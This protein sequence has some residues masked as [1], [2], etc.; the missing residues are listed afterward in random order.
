MHHGAVFYRIWIDYREV[1]NLGFLCWLLASLILVGCVCSLGHVGNVMIVN[2][3]DALEKTPSTPL[4]LAC[5]LSYQQ[6]LSSQGVQQVNLCLC[7]SKTNWKVS[8]N[9]FSIMILSC[10][11]TL[12]GSLNVKGS[13][14]RLIFWQ[15]K[16][17]QLTAP[18]HHEGKL[19][20]TCLAAYYFFQ[21]VY[22]C[23]FCCPP[24]LA[25]LLQQGFPRRTCPLG[26]FHVSLGYEDSLK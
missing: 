11:L 5:A 3:L 1:Q 19:C 14:T 7:E 13:P 9:R 2:P 26:I 25:I 8:N 6:C 10:W 12:E 15:C 24:D 17:T 23:N 20:S 21:L 16:S 18:L 22:T 4:C